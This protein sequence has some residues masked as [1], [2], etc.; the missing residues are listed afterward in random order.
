MA[1]T[2]ALAET[3][4]ADLKVALQFV[5]EKHGLEVLG[6][7]WDNQMF[8]PRIEFTSGDG[9]KVVF[10]R[11]AASVG[12]EPTDFGR[13]FS[14]SGHVHTIVGVNIGRTKPVNTRRDDGREYQWTADA[15]R[16]AL[17]T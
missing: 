3:I 15:V 17:R 5:A 4:G 1:M 12:L 8:R 2:K 6:G 11:Y 14:F 13:T 10:E 9:A 16:R 7:T